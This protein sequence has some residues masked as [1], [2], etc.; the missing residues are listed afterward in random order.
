MPAIKIMERLILPTLDEHLDVPDI[1]HG[2]RRQHSTVT[3]LNDFNQHISS[4]F[5]KK[6]P[7]DRTVLLQ[8]D[9]SKA[10]DMV[11]H[12]KLLQGLNESSLPPE[13]KRWF[14][15]YLHGR[16][17]RVKFRNKTS[18]SRNVKTGVPQGAVTSPKLFNFYLAKIPTPPEGV[19]IIQYA[20]DMSVYSS[21][22]SIPALSAAINGYV[23]SL[24]EFLRE[25]ELL[26]SPEKSTVTLFTPDTKEFKIHPQVYVENQL[27]KLDQKPKLLG[28]T[29]DTMHF[30]NHHINKTVTKAKTK[31]NIMKALAGSSWGQDK[32][33]LVMT[34]KSIVRSTLEYAAPI[35]APAISETSWSKL[36]KVQNSALRVATGS[37]FMSAP[38]HV[39]QE[40]KVLPIKPHATLLSKQFLAACH[41]PGH[42]GSKQLVRPPDARQI[43][44]T[45][46]DYSQEVRNVFP[47]LPAT[48]PT[49]K[50]AIK[51][52]HTDA[53]GESIRN[54]PENYNRVLG[55]L[56][57]GIN[58]SENTLNRKTRSEL[59]RLRS[60]FS[61]NLNNYMNRLDNEIQDV[62][63]LCNATPHDTPHL[64]DCLANPTS[65]TVIDLWTNPVEAA[66][67]L[68]I[69]NDEDA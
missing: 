66:N 21:G 4:G 39:H 43:K 3:A 12:N 59:S 42:P 36:Q 54:C 17:S 49:Y 7:P 41:L 52:L 58:P 2:F 14:N 20:D 68:K 10:F 53:V 24:T 9:L 50:T 5:N 65:L 47:S 29:F 62:C 13:I 33:T 44:H 45:I 1:Q 11:S 57:P 46:L 6:K 40:T 69:D 48:E 22:K 38:T 55:T 37:L 34:Y 19:F 56:P 27:V 23:P 15:G 60:G 28:V 31:V 32:D 30:F 25:R 64:F 18:S 8:L 51:N 26:V 63:P 67:F 35:W 61:R 16:Q